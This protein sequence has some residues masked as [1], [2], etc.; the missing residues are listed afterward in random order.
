MSSHG[1]PRGAQAATT[2]ARKHRTARLRCRAFGSASTSGNVLYGCS[3]ET[4]STITSANANA[5]ALCVY[6]KATSCPKSKL[7][8]TVSG[9]SH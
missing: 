6:E 9:A 5:A 4:T 3:F 2:G 7:P 1:M 8:S